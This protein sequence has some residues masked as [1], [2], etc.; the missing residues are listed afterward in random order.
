M[1]NL[2]DYSQTPASNNSAS[3]NG[4][5]EGMTASGVNDTMRQHMANDAGAFACYTAG[6]SADAQTVTMSPTLAAYSNK[7]RIAFIPVANNTGACTLNVNSLGAVAIKMPDG[8]DPPAGALNSSGVSVVQHNGTNFRLLNPAA[9]TLAIQNAN[10]VAITGG[11]ISGQS[12]VACAESSGVSVLMS[13]TNGYEIETSNTSGGWARGL[14]SLDGGTRTAGIGFLGSTGGAVDEI[15]LGFGSSW[16]SDGLAITATGISFDGNS[17]FDAGDIA[18]QAQ[19]ETGSSTTTLVAPGRQHFHQSAAK[20]WVDVIYSGGAPE[21]SISYNVS[22]LSD[23]GTGVATVNWATDFSSTN[24]VAIA[25]I[26]DSTGGDVIQVNSKSPGA[27]EIKI[28]DINFGGSSLDPIDCAFSVVA[29]GDH[30]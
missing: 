12:L 8:T 21:V 19:M 9:G 10:N 28:L 25:T 5:P 13:P 11:L 24:Y 23:T 29:Y 26:V 1:S 27:T 6:G 3:P 20:G 7:V 18:T 2:F 17:L 15:R 4:A 30:A 14:V 16:F 22:S